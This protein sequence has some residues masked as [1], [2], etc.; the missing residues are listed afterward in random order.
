MD[1]RMK[2]QLVNDTLLMAIWKRKPTQGLIGILIEGAILKAHHVI[3]STKSRVT[4]CPE[5]C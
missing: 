3:Q 1:S 4:L 5:K 2:A